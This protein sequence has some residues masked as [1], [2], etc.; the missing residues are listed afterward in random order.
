MVDTCLCMGAGITMAQGIN[1][2]EPETLNIA[3]I[4]DS[5]FFHTGVG[6]VI[7][8]VYNR[9]DILMVIL[10]NGTTAMTGNQAHPGTGQTALGEASERISIPGLLH[11]AGVREI[12]RA[13]PFDFAKAK[14][15]AAGL[16][17]LPG[18]RALILEGPCI[19]LERGKGSCEAAP[20][21]CV[22]CGRCVKTTGCPA[23]SLIPA[24]AGEA[25][26]HF[27]A[28]IDLALCTGCGLCASFCGFGAIRDKAEGRL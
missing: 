4:G 2:A 13:S 19:A 3:F 5:T 22:G 15:A 16:L 17:S 23:L 24:G 20:E 18:V 14:E 1:R 11:A 27:K 28:F 10:D 7:N 21:T 26:A 6:G 8:A 12:R 9:A 25:K